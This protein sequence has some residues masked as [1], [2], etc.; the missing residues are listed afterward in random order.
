MILM[1]IIMKT[2]QIS[3]IVFDENFQDK[4]NNINEKSRMNLK[5]KKKKTETTRE[6]MIKNRIEIII[7]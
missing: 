3:C 4:P 5:K 1:E 2:F 7:M 6:K